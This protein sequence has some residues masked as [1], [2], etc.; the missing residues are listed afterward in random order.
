MNA[1]PRAVPLS[2]VTFLFEQAPGVWTA[3]FSTFVGI[4]DLLGAQTSI[5]GVLQVRP[6]QSR[7]PRIQ[8][9]SQGALLMASYYYYHALGGSGVRLAM[10]AAACGDMHSGVTVPGDNH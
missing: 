5:S 2:V 1:M 10:P 6:P 9:L 7:S 8:L 3:H 4:A